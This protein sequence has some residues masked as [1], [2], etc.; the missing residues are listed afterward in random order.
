MLVPQHHLHLMVQVDDYDIEM[1]N[2]CKARLESE[3]LVDSGG[4]TSGA[5]GASRAGAGVVEIRLSSKEITYLREVIKYIKSKQNL[6]KKK[7]FFV[8]RIKQALGLGQF[9]GLDDE[10]DLIY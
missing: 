5:S 7:D 9:A 3:S 1:V 8:H 4:G 6:A 2:K 10:I